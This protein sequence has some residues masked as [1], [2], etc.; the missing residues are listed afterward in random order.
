MLIVATLFISPLLN[1]NI[2]FLKTENFSFTADMMSYLMKSEMDEY[3]E[4]HKSNISENYLETVSLNPQKNLRNQKSVYG[5]TWFDYFYSLALEEAKTILVSCEAAHNEKILLNNEDENNIDTALSKINSEDYDI[6]QKNLKKF[7]RYKAISDKYKY[8]FK[9]KLSDSDYEQYYKKN[10][11]EFD[12]VDYKRVVVYANIDNNEDIEEAT[13]AASK[14]AEELLTE[15]MAEGFDA[16][17]KRHLDKI[18][19]KDTIEDLTFEAQRYLES[20]QFNDWAFDSERKTGD[21]VIFPGK[22]QFSIYYLARPSYPYD[23]TLSKG[24]IVFGKYDSS[25]PRVLT[26]LKN[27]LETQVENDQ[28]LEVFSA[29]NGFKNIASSD[30]Y[31]DDLP[32]PVCEWLYSKNRKTGDMDVCTYGKNIYI[33]RYSEQG[34]SYFKSKLAKE[35]QEYEYNKIINEFIS[36]TNL[37]VQENFKFLLLR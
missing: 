32:E 3:I 11:K 26:E 27:K 16:P 7:L 25:N 6:S 33:M 8:D 31:K 19:S 12:C 4:Y 35:C 20:T 18:D 36:E 15:I 1:S 21:A 29:D 17:V 22:Y 14:K 9:S 37:K 23:Y 2:T 13:L 30:L 28:D 5:G 10:R 34:E 24:T